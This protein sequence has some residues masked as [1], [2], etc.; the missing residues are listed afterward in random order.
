[1]GGQRL[2]FIVQWDVINQRI[3][4]VT[5]VRPQL[6]VDR[7]SSSQIHGTLTKYKSVT[8]LVAEESGGR[9]PRQHL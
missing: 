9:R 2:V 5:P 4:Q 7:K 3:L 8:H 1:M 6:E